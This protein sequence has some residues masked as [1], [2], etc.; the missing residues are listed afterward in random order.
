MKMHKRVAV[1][2]IPASLASL[3]T[4]IGIAKQAN[5]IMG[6]VY[7]G[8][9]VVTPLSFVSQPQSKTVDE[10]SLATFSCEV[11]GGVAPY[12]YQY[13]K[14]GANVG[15]NSAAL[16]F[17]A[18]A[19]DKNASITVTVTDSAGTAITS[20]TAALAV[21]SYAFQFDGTTQN[22]VLSSPVA[23]SILSTFE[24]SVDIYITEIV[25]ANQAIF[26]GD[27]IA[28]NGNFALFTYNG[29]VNSQLPTTTGARYG[30]GATLN[31]NAWNTVK[32]SWDLTTMKIIVNG[33]DGNVS[34]TN[35]TGINVTTLASFATSIRKKCR[36]RNF[37]AKVNGVT[38]GFTPLNNKSQG[39]NQ[40]ATVG[41]TDAA[42]VNYN[43][44]GWA[45]I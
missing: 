16:S 5:M 18:A 29:V 20:T 4:G 15:T 33:V 25:A 17:T 34:S 27:N 11:T 35:V 26:G 42:I 3:A 43:A 22:A 8:G 14:N 41:S 10:Y 28:A 30:S 19:T 44:S 31:L 37:E 39:A 12:T 45:S 6:A 24:V 21:V 36:L 38:V 2:G 32:L 13:K 40:A 23:A 7:G 1:G 9:G